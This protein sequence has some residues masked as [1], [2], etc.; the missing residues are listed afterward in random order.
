MRIGILSAELGQEDVH[1]N[2]R[3]VREIRLKGHR[4]KIINYRKTVIIIS[5]NRCLLYQPDE[6]GLL[7]QVQVDAVIPRINE[8]DEQSMNLASLALETLISNGAYSTASPTSIRQAKSKIR[9]LTVMGKAGVPVPRSAG[10]TGTESYEVDIDRVL[11]AVEPNTSKR[12]IVKTNVGTHGKGVMLANSRGEARAIVEGL[13]ANNIP[14][15]VQQFIEPTKKGA[16]EDL[17][18]I[19]VNGQVVGAMKRSST[20]KDEFRANISLGGKGTAYIPSDSE[21]EMAKNA[22][23]ALGLSVAGVDMIASGRGR[24]IIEVNTSPGFAI[25]EIVKINLAK[26]IVQLAVSGARRGERN[27]AQKISDMLK[28]EVAM[29]HIKPIAKPKLIPMKKLIYLPT[30]KKKSP[31]TK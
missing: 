7:H 24:L 4:P 5:N 26:K 10:L 1:E 27:S 25:E 9:S 12:I 23:K 19:L 3:L 6:K 28:S 15:I 16:Y 30:L 2:K 20:K 13:L 29:P 31:K 11:K 8:A 21:I 22:A 14:V 18:F 17:R